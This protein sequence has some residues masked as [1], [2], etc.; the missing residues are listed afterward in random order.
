MSEYNEEWFNI[1][2]KSEMRL[3]DIST[4]LSNYAQSFYSV[5]NVKIGGLLSGISVELEN[6]AKDIGRASGE[7]T[8]NMVN[9]AQNNSRNVLE[10]A[11]AGIKLATK[12][13]KG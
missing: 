6:M 4:I 1:L 9:S 10:A 3:F 11:L 5:G 12:D 7:V 2:S 8:T 13:K